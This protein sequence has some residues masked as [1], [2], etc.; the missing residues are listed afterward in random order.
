MSNP[1]NQNKVLAFKGEKTKLQ[2]LDRES[3]TSLFCPS[4]YEFQGPSDESNVKME[5]EEALLSTSQ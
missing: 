4:G 3:Y 1:S 2:K 5:E